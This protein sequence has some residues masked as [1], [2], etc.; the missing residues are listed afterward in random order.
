MHRWGRWH[1]RALVRYS[2]SP[3][4][5]LGEPTGVR[6][7]QQRARSHR[8]VKGLATIGSFALIASLLMPGGAAGIAAPVDRTGSV[9]NSADVSPA[10]PMD[11]SAPHAAPADGHHRLDPAHGA[12][13][14][15][16]LRRATENELRA[17]GF[18]AVPGVCDGAFPAGPPA[19][20]ATGHG[21]PTEPAACT[22]GGDYVASLAP[23]SDAPALD[24]GYSSPGIPC[25]TSGPFVHVFYAYSSSG[26]NRITTVGPRIRETVSR[27]DPSETPLCGFRSKA[28]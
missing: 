24:P 18:R 21:A 8:P 12:A 19:A 11:E 2:T 5:Q 16:V 10:R 27:I 15:V 26:T 20:A 22:H 3:R 7:E 28:C 23:A 4:N 14:L 9:A 1:C 17:T 25:Y 6:R 13:S